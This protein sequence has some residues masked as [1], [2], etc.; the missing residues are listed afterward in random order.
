MANIYG[1]FFYSCIAGITGAVV[2]SW[3]TYQFAMRRI[4]K[5]SKIMR[6]YS[7]E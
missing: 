5:I 4:K 3:I 1:L 6:L 2:G 7:D